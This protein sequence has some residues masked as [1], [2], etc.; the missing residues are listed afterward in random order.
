[1]SQ[2]PVEVVA[3]EELSAFTP[4][5]RIYLWGAGLVLVATAA[6]VQGASH[7]RLVGALGLLWAVHLVL[8][9]EF[10]GRSRLAPRVGGMISSLGGIVLLPAIVLSTGQPVETLLYVALTCLPLVIAALAPDDRGSVLVFALG[11]LGWIA[12]IELLTEHGPAQVAGPIALSASC[13]IIALVAT[14]RFERA[15]ET[16][17]RSTGDRIVALEQLAA[18]ERLR[19][20]TARLAAIGQISAG[21]AHEI[22]N[23]LAFV[24][25]NVSFLHAAARGAGALDADVDD[26]FRETGAGLQRIRQI[27]SDLGRLS[28]SDGADDEAGSC[29]PVDAAQEALRLASVRLK[30]PIRVE[31]NFSADPPAVAMSQHRLVQVL[32]NLLVNAADAVEHSAAPRV[33]LGSTRSGDVFRI[34]VDDSGT[35]IPPHILPDLFEPFFTTKPPGKGTGLGLALCRQYLEGVGGRVHAENRPEGGARFTIELPCAAAAAPA[36]EAP[37]TAGPDPRAT[38]ALSGQRFESCSSTSSRNE[39]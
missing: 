23:P 18:S 20:G 10:V 26:A 1:M 11:G 13:S 32:L 22:N 33:C 2:L 8:V 9:G 37:V 31:T 24:S 30:L 29:A 34:T 36:C 5:R 39:A 21:V 19:A 12:V 28:R 17:R 16:Q 7:P 35:G 38:Q 6:S 14:F 27:V 25:A 3:P 4:R 15:Q